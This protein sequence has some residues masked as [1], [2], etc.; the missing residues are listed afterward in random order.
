M[1]NLIFN[2]ITNY[3]AG[4]EA[5]DEFGLEDDVAI[6]NGDGNAGGGDRIGDVDG[7][8]KWLIGREGQT[9]EEDRL[10]VGRGEGEDAVG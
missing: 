4:S 10:F 6:G 2:C 5:I 1:K 8:E 7:C 3:V 9:V